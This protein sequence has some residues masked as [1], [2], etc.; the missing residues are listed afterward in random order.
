MKITVLC[1]GSSTEREVSLRSGAAVD[2]CLREAGHTASLLDVRSISEAI[3]SEQICS[4]DIVFL[5]LHGGWGED[6]RIQSALDT[7]HIPYTG[8]GAAACWAAMDKDISRR[9]MERSGM[10]VPN[11]TSLIP[12]DRYDFFSAIKKWGTIVIKPASGGSTV[13]VT[14]TS[15]ANEAA[16]G[17]M[18][19]WEIDTKAVVE[20]YIPGHEL[21]AAV[22]GTGS[23][24]VCMPLVEIVP[25]SGFYDYSSKY[26]SGASKYIV[27]A[28]ISDDAV[29]K[30]QKQAVLAHKAHGCAVYSRVD[31]RMTDSGEIYALEVN[32]APG[33]TS[34]SLVP[35]AAAAYGWDFE[36]LLNEIIDKSLA[37]RKESCCCQ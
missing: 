6:G 34:T 8:S 25:N 4:A 22:F 37:V 28:E 24:T 27:P 19:V 30:V 12:G 14:I 3:E 17:L 23:S 33:M 11:G 26:T 20:Q 2:R 36:T 35:K 21:T 5:A 31:F 7:L 1:G 13:G 15:D 32:T 29:S 10:T 18:K 9:C 16:L